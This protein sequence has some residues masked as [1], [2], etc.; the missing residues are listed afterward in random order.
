[1]VNKISF[2][3]FISA[4]GRYELVQ[5]MSCIEF[6]GISLKF[7]QYWTLYL[8]LR[9]CQDMCHSCML[10]FYKWILRFHNLLMDGTFNAHLSET[11]QN[12]SNNTTHMISPAT[13][14]HPFSNWRSWRLG[15]P[16]LHTK[17]ASYNWTSLHF[18]IKNNWHRCKGVLLA[19]YPLWRA[20]CHV[21]TCPNKRH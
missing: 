6:E 14:L 18:Y 1:M 21:S 10:W 12:C 3:P 11:F 13:P 9:S 19:K 4:I 5:H 7:D 2:T 15:S 16:P 17:T 20:H 8:W